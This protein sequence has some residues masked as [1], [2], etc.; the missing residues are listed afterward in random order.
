M[1]LSVV[2]GPPLE[3]EPGLGAL[4]LPGY[5]REVTARYA[6][7]EALVMHHPDGSVERWSYADLWARAMAVARAL[8]AVGVGKD[9]R[10]GVLMTNRPEWLAAVFGV[11]LAGGVAATLSTFSTP[12]ELEILIQASCCSVLLFERTVLKKDFA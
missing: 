12:A 3:A 11:G 4:T 8:T 2:Y 6:G 5:L 9:S 7:R 10:V 1:D